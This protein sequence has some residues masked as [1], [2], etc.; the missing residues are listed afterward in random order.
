MCVDISDVER[1]PDLD[2]LEPLQQLCRNLGTLISIPGETAGQSRVDG[3]LRQQLTHAH[4]LL[5][6]SRLRQRELDALTQLRTQLYSSVLHD[7]RTPLAAVRGYVKIVLE[8]HAEEIET[9]P[10]RFL[11]IALENA[12]KLTQLL[13]RFAR[14]ANGPQVRV[15]FLDFRALWTES[16]Q[17]LRPQME[18]NSIRLVERGA[19]GPLEVMGDRQKLWLV[20]Y[21]LLADAVRSTSHGGHILAE[22]VRQEDQIKIRI[23]TRGEPKPG[24]FAE[25]SA[26]VV[27]RTHKLS[28][29]EAGDTG[30]SAAQDTVWLH[31]GTISVT[32]GS[33]SGSCCT[34]TLPIFPAN[35]FDGGEGSE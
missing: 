2:S 15:E 17:F 32:N 6:E 7:L 21:R 14:L 18:R 35:N 26:P 28:A 31:G 33:G 29:Q 27:D 20:I 25:R 30:F 3:D 19:A 23:S 16:L 1:M 4:R 9:A 34:L 24:E 13:N 12:N 22:F 8:D 5:A 10:E 11:K